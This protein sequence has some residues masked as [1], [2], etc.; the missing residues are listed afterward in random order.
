MTSSEDREEGS[1]LSAFCN[2]NQQD[3]VTDHKRWDR[4]V[5]KGEKRVQKD[6]QIPGVIIRVTVGPEE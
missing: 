3:L 2:K 4:A 6:S 1:A 5:G